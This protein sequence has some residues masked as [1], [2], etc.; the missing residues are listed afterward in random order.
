M[1]KNVH[2]VAVTATYDSSHGLTGSESR[3]K[4]FATCNLNSHTDIN[5]LRDENKELSENNTTLKSFMHVLEQQ[6]G[7]AIGDNRTQAFMG[8][9]DESKLF[10][11]KYIF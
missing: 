7:T 11:S 8:Q 9:E 10:C 4:Y 2:L 1:K 3:H 5:G 6:L